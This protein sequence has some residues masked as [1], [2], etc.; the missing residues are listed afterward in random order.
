MK[1]IIILIAAALVS[2]QAQFNDFHP[3]LNWFTIKGEKVVVHYHE[4]AERTARVVCKIGDE[5]WDQ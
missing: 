5:I 2:I 1:K 3:E 4:G